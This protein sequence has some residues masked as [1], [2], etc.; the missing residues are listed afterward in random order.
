MRR[1]GFGHQQRQ[2]GQPH[3]VDDGFALCIEQPPIAVQE[4]HEQ[5]G[6]AALVAIGKRV[7]LDHEVQQMRRLGFDAGIGRLAKHGLVEIA[8]LGCQAI[9]ALTRKEVGGF[10]TAHQVGL[11]AGQ[12]LAGLVGARQGAT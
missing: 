11:Q 4:I 1:I 3:V 10:A 5:E 2:R 7:V 9:A 6:A 8:E 12:R